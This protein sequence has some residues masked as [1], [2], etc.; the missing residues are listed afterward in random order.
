MTVFARTASTRTAF[1][2]HPDAIEAAGR[3]G[4]R[5]DVLCAARRSHSAPI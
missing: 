1:L 3:H 4:D 5:P 2:A